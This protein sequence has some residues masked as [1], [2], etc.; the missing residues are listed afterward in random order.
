M[1]DAGELLWDDVPEERETQS[2]RYRERGRRKRGG[3]I[4]D[5]LV[6]G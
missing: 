3:L 2:K 1:E 4:N 5:R 6:S